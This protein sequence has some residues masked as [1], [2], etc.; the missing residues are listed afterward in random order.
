MILRSI[1]V[2][3]AREDDPLVLIDI[4]LTKKQSNSIEL[5][6]Y[7]YFDINLYRLQLQWTRTGRIAASLG[8]EERFNLNRHYN[9]TV[10]LV[11]DTLVFH[12]FPNSHTPIIENITDYDPLPFDVFLTD[13][14]LNSGKSHFSNYF[15]QKKMFFGN[16][17]AIKPDY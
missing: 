16:G 13:L 14:S 2:Y 12:Q 5:D 3:A 9:S 6:F 15:Y 17:G 7:Q 4:T 1:T 8:D 11:N 10:Q